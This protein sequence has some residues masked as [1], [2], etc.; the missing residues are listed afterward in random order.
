MHAE[1]IQYFFPYEA[2]FVS[3][4]QAMV[5]RRTLMNASSCRT[6]G[7]VGLQFQVLYGEV[8]SLRQAGSTLG[9]GVI[10]GDSPFWQGAKQA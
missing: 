1:D 2:Y 4:I 3:T 9:N 10:T 6:E 5:S 7:R 8:D